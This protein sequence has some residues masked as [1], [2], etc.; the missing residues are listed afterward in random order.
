MSDNSTPLLSAPWEAV[1]QAALAALETDDE[2]LLARVDAA[3]HHRFLNALLRGKGRDELAKLLFLVL[4]SGKA[5]EKEIRETFP[6]VVN[7]WNHMSELL[8]AVRESADPVDEVMRF[9]DTKHG[10]KLLRAVRDAGP[11]GI[12]QGDL[13]KQLRI[14]DSNTSRLVSELQ[15]RNIV[16]RHSMG[17]RKFVTLGLLGQLVLEPQQPDVAEAPVQFMNLDD[18]RVKIEWEAAA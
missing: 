2:N 14:Q 15:G 18:C 5:R 17:Q 6:R 11:L 9:L 10:W 13:A 4:E 12:T 1:Q 7:E 8:V 16:E 3:I